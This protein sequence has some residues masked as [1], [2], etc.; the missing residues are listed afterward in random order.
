MGYGQRLKAV[1]DNIG[2]VQRAVLAAILL[3]FIAAGVM[4]SRW[5][6]RPEMRVLYQ[7]VAP[8][9]AATIVEKIAEKG[10]EYELR[11]GGTSIYVPREQ[12]YQLRLDMAKDGL[13]SG[14]ATGYKLFDDEKIGISPFVQSVNLKR[15]LQDELAQSIQMMEGVMHAR[16]HIVEPEKSIFADEGANTTASVVLKMQAGYRMSAQNIAA[17]THLVAGSVKGLK[18]ENVTVVDSQGRLLSSD[19]DPELNNG[20]NSVQEYRERV[21]DNLSKKV[22]DMLK[23]VLGP[24]R[25][26]VKVSA[27]VD[28]NSVN[29]VK[30]MYEPKGV[31][32]KEEIKETNEKEG[33][34]P[35]GDA[36]ATVA[37]GTKTD[38][39]IMTEYALGKTV[40]EETV[41]PGRIVEVK[42]AA[43]VDLSPAT[44]DVNDAGGAATGML[45][46]LTEVE[47]IIK[48][49]L[50]L[51][52][53]SSIKVV[54]VKFNRPAEAAVEEA[55]GLDIVA[56][57][58]QASMGLMAVCALVVLKMFS[59]RSK[60]AKKEAAG[61][62]TAELAETG[63][64]AGLLAAGAESAEPLMLRKQIASALERNPEQVKQLF[65]S[66]IE[67]KA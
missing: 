46:P 50:G 1:W 26:S 27:T 15:A 60:K 8:E 10:I 31:A 12:V 54:N 35:T 63:G 33:E 38:S 65:S 25:A 7:E 21:E 43:F 34:T 30:E 67:Q 49:A 29:T 57:A 23:A 3:T 2:L 20:A 52:N 64:A 17:I 44:A 55:E 11:D 66:W 58:G 41:L 19:S 28:M 48:N 14:G 32:K 5:A 22:E 37:G 56:I 61:G 45:M 39:T 18:S 42:V 24:G 47:E 40:K 36:G 62:V 9:E 4:V 13:P 53:G 59:G 51:T 6:G 16:V